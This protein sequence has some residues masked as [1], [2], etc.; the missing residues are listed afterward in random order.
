VKDDGIGIAA[1]M[2]PK[3]FEAFTQVDQ[4][5]ARSQGGSASGCRL[6]NAWWKCTVAR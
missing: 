3:V 2:L 5:I 4:S 6:P 1:E